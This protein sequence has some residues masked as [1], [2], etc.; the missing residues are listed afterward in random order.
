[1]KPIKMR[2][3][4]KFVKPKRKKQYSKESKKRNLVRWKQELRGV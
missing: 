2:V 1:M 3:A 4:G